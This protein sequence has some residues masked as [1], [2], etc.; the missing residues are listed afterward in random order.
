MTMRLTIAAAMIVGLTA[1]A[2]AQ[3]IG[4]GM[5]PPGANMGFPQQQQQQQMPPCFQEFAPIR[6]EAEKRAT[7]LKAVMAK[8]PPREEA[9]KYIKSFA[10]AEA[11]VVKF[12]NANQQQCGI[13][14]EAVSKM[15]TNHGRTMQMQ[16]QVCAA[17]AG[18]AKPTG[19]G[20][21]EAL[22]TTRSGGSLDPLAPK[23][24]T[25][26]TLTGNILTR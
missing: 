17:Q 21:S 7:V 10:E 20:L 6:S 3:M 15:K 5:A 18:P 25:L 22:G 12:I 26:D 2:G 4:P 16:N 11:R 23:S 9:C 8:K 13:P 24:G 1:T 14:L 19:P